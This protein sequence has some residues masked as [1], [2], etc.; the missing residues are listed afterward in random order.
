MLT[1]TVKYR[2]KTEGKGVSSGRMEA[3]GSHLSVSEATIDRDKDGEGAQVL[4][5]P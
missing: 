2:V 4:Q 5:G 1:C 3:G